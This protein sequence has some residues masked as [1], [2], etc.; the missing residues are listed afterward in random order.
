MMN[1]LFNGSFQWHA[2]VDNLHNEPEFLNKPYTWIGS[3]QFNGTLV[4]LNTTTELNGTFTR[5]NNVSPILNGP[6]NEIVYNAPR[7]KAI[8]LPMPPQVSV[9]NNVGAAFGWTGADG[10]VYTD[11]G[12]VPYTAEIAL[13]TGCIIT[14]F[15]VAGHTQG[16]PGLSGNNF[17]AGLYKSTPRGLAGGP[18]DVVPL[19]PEV[20]A[21]V[22]GAGFGNDFILGNTTSGLAETVNRAQSKYYVKAYSSG[23]PVLDT[24][25]QIAVT[26]NDPGPR[27]G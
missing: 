17:R 15:V 8:L 1:W 25:Y 12:D 19:L 9:M 6:A 11:D 21:G 20:A 5:F 7:A 23:Q 22:S 4:A 2:Y 14:G 24:I 26:F 13:P 18:P 27:N 16:G 10:Y 3:H